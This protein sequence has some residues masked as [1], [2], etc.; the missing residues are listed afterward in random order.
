MKRTT[1]QDQIRIRESLCEKLA[2]MSLENAEILSSGT[3]I[4]NGIILDTNSQF[5]CRALRQLHIA[6]T[7]IVSLPDDRESMMEYARMAL[8][9][10]DLLIVTGGLGPTEDDMSMEAIASA[11]SLPLCEDEGCLEHI[12]AYFA[13]RSGTIPPA[14]FKQALLPE[15][16]LRLPNPNGTACGAFY[17]VF[18]EGKNRWIIM[19]PGPPHEMQPMFE[20]SIIPLLSDHGAHAV[21]AQSLRCYGIGES[22]LM[23]KIEDLLHLDPAVQITSYVGQGEILLRVESSRT[24][25][26][27]A[28]SFNEILSALKERLG[29]LIFDLGDRHLEEVLV[30]ELKERRLK[31]FGA[32]SCTGG[33]ISS[34]IAAV[35]GASEV[36]KGALVSYREEIKSSCLGVREE[37]LKNEGAVS[38]ACAVAMA[39]GARRLSGSDLAYAVTG[40]A[41]PGGGDEKNPMGSVYFALSDAEK[42]LVMRKQYRGSRQRVRE[43]ATAY[44]LNACRLWIHSSLEP[45]WE[46]QSS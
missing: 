14:N 44:V 6:C 16:A 45:E 25:E 17:S 18:Y 19:L 3:E 8:R 4:M 39:E 31:L 35:A 5:L 11:F 38:A 2:L 9:R 21:L 26:G 24:E 33:M 30:D 12:K 22:A 15:G 46:R 34:R 42:T 41:G 28:E 20:K 27:A 37:V 10:C 32:E 36:F 7:R 40:Y 23:E 1:E 43:Q 13:S 29:H